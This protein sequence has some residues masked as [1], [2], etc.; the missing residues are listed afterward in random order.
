MGSRNAS[1]QVSLIAF[2]CAVAEHG[3]CP[4][5][6]LTNLLNDQQQL[7]VLSLPAAG[8]HCC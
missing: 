6:L 7:H 8:K 5:Q 2:Y 1:M 3:D 4:L